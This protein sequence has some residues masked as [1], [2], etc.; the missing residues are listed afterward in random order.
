MNGKPE[1]VAE[2]LA[3]AENFYPAYPGL[4]ELRGRL[5]VGS[6]N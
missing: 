3:A 2:L 1:I 5:A 4:A 6:G